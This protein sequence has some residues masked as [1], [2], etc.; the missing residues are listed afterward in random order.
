MPRP[1]RG[2]PMKVYKRFGPTLNLKSSVKTFYFY[3]TSPKF[4]TSQKCEILAQF[5]S[6][7]NFKGPLFRNKAPYR[8]S[9]NS[10]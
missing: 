7:V 1:S 4:Y 9:K 10:T 8:K 3:P 5:S 6:P 2:D